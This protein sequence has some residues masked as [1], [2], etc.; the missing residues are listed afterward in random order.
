[1]ESSYTKYQPVL[2]SIVI[3]RPEDCDDLV[4]GLAGYTCL[5][6]RMQLMV[7]DQIDAGYDKIV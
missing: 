2:S 7:S 3:S 1:M 5:G 6:I 4:L